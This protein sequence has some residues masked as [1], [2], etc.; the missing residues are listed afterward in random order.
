[1]TAPRL[2]NLRALNEVS[3][4]WLSTLNVVSFSS[5]G[6]QMLWVFGSIVF[7]LV[8]S[9]LL[10]RAGPGSELQRAAGLELTFALLT[11]W[12]GKSVITAAQSHGKRTTDTGFM[13]AKAS[14]E[15][16][17]RAHPAAVVDAT[18]A[19][20]VS[21]V[22]GADVV[23]PADAPPAVPPPAF[24]PPSDAP[25]DAEDHEHTWAPTGGKEGLG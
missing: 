6:N 17:K 1:M 22:T 15:E 5:V 3:T 13:Q 25:V 16:A 2:P 9:W 11:A 14:L 23:P 4:S 7:T 18:N 19:Q 8:A 10:T 20:N 21:V 12:T 24:T